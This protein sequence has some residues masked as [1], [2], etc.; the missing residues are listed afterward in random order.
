[1]ATSS[2]APLHTHRLGHALSANE[3]LGS[4]LQRLAASKA[5]FAVIEPLLPPPLRP[6]TRPGVLED[7]AWVLLAD[8]AAAAAKL[9]QLLPTLQSALAAAGWAE[10]AA[11]IKVSPPR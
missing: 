11:R 5:R 8:N 7:G 9:R 4:L 3:T 2:A 1:M 10:P 6:H